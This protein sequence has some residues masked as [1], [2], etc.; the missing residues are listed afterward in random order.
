[1]G[2]ATEGR[3]DLVL[4][5]GP[6]DQRKLREVQ[7]ERPT[8]IVTV[9]A[10]SDT[11]ASYRTLGAQGLA[12]VVPAL[13]DKS[14][15]SYRKIAISAFSKGG[16]FTDEI[17]KDPDTR[18]R[19]DAVILNDAVFGSQHSGLQ[20]FLDRAA[21]GEKLM[22]VTNTNNRASA[23]LPKRARESVED[24]IGSEVG[25]RLDETAPELGMPTPSGGVWQLGDFFWYDYVKPT[26]ENDISH[27]AHHDL[28]DET[29]EAHLVPYFKGVKFPVFLA[30]AG[31]T[32]MIGAIVWLGR[33]N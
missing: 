3:P 12:Q 26:G 29:W 2:V 33:K 24:L 13:T 20:P 8:E 5:V 7:F 9:H 30:A 15:N 27:A 10:P 32:A 16:S 18:D 25:T 11:S 31:L 22:V 23:A 21:A 19:V 14:V 4:F 6:V 17:L 28:A 1:M